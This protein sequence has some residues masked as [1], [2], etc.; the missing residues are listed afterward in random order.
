MSLMPLDPVST[1]MLEEAGPLPDRVLVLDDPEGDLVAAVADAG[2]QVRAWNDDVRDEAQVPVDARLTGPF[3]GWSPDLVLWR[4]PR[5]LSALEDYAQ[6]LANDLPAH[7]RVIAGARI[8]H[9]TPG[10]N[11]V[12]RRSFAEVSAS[13]GRQ[14]ARVLR[15]SGP[16]PTAPRWPQRRYVPELGVTAVAHGS[17]FATNRLDPG[18]HLLLRTLARATAET[19]DAQQ[20]PRGAAID[21]GCGSGLIAT[22]LASQGWST[23]A[24]DV[25][26]YALLST[27]LTA[28]AQNAEVALRRAD[29]LVGVPHD[30]VDLIVSNPPFHRGAAKDSTPTFAMIGAAKAALHPG[31]ELWLVFNS[32]LPYLPALRAQ[33]GP[34]TVE[35]QDRSFIVT[36]TLK[37]PTR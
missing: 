1:L 12:L 21:L 32:H 34:T 2:V 26:R 18:T 14:K 13:L 33:V 23:T 37:E 35:A 11:A 7:A 5:A 29:G 22:W 6:T 10:Q 27:Q 36:R 31:G 25:S 4:L 30:S 15:A 9:M 16:L 19:G 3:T 8:K 28:R 17:V 20:R 24:I